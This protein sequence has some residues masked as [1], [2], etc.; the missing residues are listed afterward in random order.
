MLT[1]SYYFDSFRKYQTIVS[2]ETLETP[3]SRINYNVY[4]YE[5]YKKN[6]NNN[7]NTH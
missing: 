6:I 2:C 4:I 1:L 7:K 5:L 3:V